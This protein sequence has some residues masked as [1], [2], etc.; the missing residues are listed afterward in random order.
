MYCELRAKGKI[1]NEFYNKQTREY[2]FKNFS[3]KINYLMY[4]P[5][6]TSINCLCFET[7]FIPKKIY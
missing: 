2:S 5:R 7:Y 3:N 1:L 4:C 6:R